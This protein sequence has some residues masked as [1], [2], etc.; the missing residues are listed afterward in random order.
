MVVHA[1]PPQPR[2]RMRQE[3]CQ[4]K[5]NVDNLARHFS[6]PTQAPQRPSWSLVEEY[7]PSVSLALSLVSKTEREEEEERKKAEE[8]RGRRG[9]REKGGEAAPHSLSLDPD[10]KGTGEP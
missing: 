3:N 10:G 9:G 4:F 8:D 5:A 6:P 7:L 1:C 2:E